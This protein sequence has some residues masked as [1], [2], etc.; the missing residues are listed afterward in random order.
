MPTASPDAAPG[1]C[2]TQVDALIDLDTDGPVE[3]ELVGTGTGIATS[4]SWHVDSRTDLGALVGRELVASAATSDVS[5]AAAP[6]VGLTSEGPFLVAVREGT[7]VAV[8][9]RSADG[10][11]LVLPE[12]AWTEGPVHDA[13]S[14]VDPGGVRAG[15]DR[16]AR[17]TEVAVVGLPLV[18]CGTADAPGGE[19]LPAGDYA[20][21]A[22][23]T[24]TAGGGTL[25]RAVDGPWS[26]E[27]LGDGTADASVPADLP[28]DVPV[29]AGTAPQ[30]VTLPGTTEAR[31]LVVVAVDG[32]DA[33]LRAERAL[34]EAGFV[35]PVPG[36][37]DTLMPSGG[38]V[39]ALHDDR[40]AV[41]LTE[42][43]TDGRRELV[44]RIRER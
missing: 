1:E 37:D 3:I 43:V 2:G 40:Y 5:E 30:V 9:D 25:Q 31:W 15:G 38:H 14:G 19:P 17:S 41:E 28:A 18:T 23:R 33:R 12:R 11:A 16:D 29:I 21:Y 34:T 7:I 20:V 13:L 35:H 39:L 42:Q 8:P 10:R 24:Y 32:T 26:L 36:E 4:A 27:L 22:Y 6:P 44:Y